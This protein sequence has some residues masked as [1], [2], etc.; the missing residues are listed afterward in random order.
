MDRHVG[1][2]HADG[3]ATRGWFVGDFIPPAEGGVR[4]TSTFETKWC[5]CR[6]G[7]RRTTPA[8]TSSGTTMVILV[9]GQLRLIFD[10]IDALLTQPGDYAMWNG[11]ANHTWAAE[12]DS[13]V[14][15]FRTPARPAR[16]GED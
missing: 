6:N 15:T 14:I 11:H 3:M 8:C 9:S 10:D 16:P 13:V 12:A 4:S 2:A 5:V 7:D 1:N